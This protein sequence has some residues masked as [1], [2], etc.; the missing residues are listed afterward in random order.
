VPTLEVR[1]DNSLPDTQNSREL[2]GRAPSR[3]AAIARW[4]DGA[5]LPGAAR[6]DAGRS[7]GRRRCRRHGAIGGRQLLT[8]PGPRGSSLPPADAAPPLP[9]ELMRL[10]PPFAGDPDAELALKGAP[11]TRCRPEHAFLRS[12]P[13]DVEAP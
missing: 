5:A 4:Q 10:N 9:Q 13:T 2:P 8:A 7:A 11:A 6:D 1:V 12:R 3:A